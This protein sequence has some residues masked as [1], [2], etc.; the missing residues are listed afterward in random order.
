MNTPLPRDHV[1]LVLK[2]LDILIPSLQIG[3][4]KKNVFFF[5]F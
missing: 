4:L 5:L 3:H 1:W 2:P